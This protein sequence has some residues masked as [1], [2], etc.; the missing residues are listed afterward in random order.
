MACLGEELH[1]ASASRSHT[2]FVLSHATDYFI[3]K[4]SSVY[5]ASL[6][7]SKA[8]DRVH[9]IKLINKLLLYS[10]PGERFMADLLN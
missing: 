4:G 5:I 1:Y 9:H 3:S 6:G 8:F 7:V 10:T 2:L